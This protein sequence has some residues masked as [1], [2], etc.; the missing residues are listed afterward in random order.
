MFKQL[1]INITLANALIIILKYQQ[2]LKALL[3]NKKKLLEMANTPLNENCLTI[4]LKKLPEKLGDP[5]KFLISCGFS[6]LKC[7]ALADLGRPFL[8]TARALIDVHREEIILCD[9]DERLTSNMRHDTSSYSNQPQKESNNM[10]NIY[11]DSYEDYLEDLFATNHLSGNP[12][13]SSQT[14]LTSPEVINPLSGGTTSSSP[15]H[16]LEE[17]IKYL[18]N[19][20]P[21]KEIDSI[22][23]DSVDEC[24]L[25]DPNNNLVDTISEM[26]IDEHTLD[27]S[28]PRLYDDVDGDLVELESDNDDVYNDPF[29]SKE[30]KIKESKLL[31][32][33]LDPPRLSAF[34][35]SPEYDSFLFKDFFRG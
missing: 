33:E 30:D 2:M 32:Y 20:D 18:L 35:P 21:T 4:I 26:F 14:D 15:D 3:S 23:E 25:A 24:N 19:H 8:Q 22:L 12:T 6:E 11:N 27:Y 34:L 5:W 17:E 16:L 13:F 28:S 1:H 31:I 10:I 29:D 7:K 9:G